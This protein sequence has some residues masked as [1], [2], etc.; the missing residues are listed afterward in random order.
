VQGDFHATAAGKMHHSGELTL[1][2]P[3]DVLLAGTLGTGD[4]SFRPRS[5]LLNRTA[6]P[7]S[8]KTS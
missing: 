8:S 7:T 6:T 4:L 1:A 2:R 3:V 5:A